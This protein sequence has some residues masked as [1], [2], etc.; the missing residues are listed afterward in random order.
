MDALRSISGSLNQ[1][2]AC[3]FLD[4]T[5]LQ[6]HL[7]ADSV[8]SAWWP[9]RHDTHAHLFSNTALFVS[10]SQ[11]QALSEAV[12]VL[13]E[14]MALPAWR[15][16]ALAQAPAIA[17]VDRGPYG[18][19]M[20]YDFHLTESGP[21]LIEINTNAGGAM[22]NLALT[23]AQH[24]CCDAGAAWLRTATDVARLE[25]QWLDM[26]AQEWALQRGAEPF[27]AAQ[28]PARTLAIVDEDPRQQYLYPE[29]LLFQH[30]FRQA[31]VDAV[32][33]APQELV[34]AQGQLQHQGR[35]V[36]MVYCRLTDFYLD[37]PQHAHLREAFTSGVCVFTPGPTA[38]A[39]HANKRHLAALSDPQVLA[40]M[41]VTQHMRQALA[42]V[43]PQTEQV[44]PQSAERLWA[45]RKQYFF[46]PLAGYG[47]KATYRGDKLTTK[48][49]AHIV[50]GDYVAQALIPPSQRVVRVGEQRKHL[51]ADVRAYAYDGWVQLFAARLYEGQTTNFRSDGGGFAPVFVTPT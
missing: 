12:Q 10:Q 43:V 25:S 9:G 42:Q 27:V 15:A 40:Q 14:A 1:G 35:R 48:T 4:E 20:G 28:G 47:S 49:W 24:V 44:T 16:Q 3:Y 33:A 36:D 29:F 17:Q 18:V 34:W 19:F 2:C 30:M 8:L 38:H 32:I 22:L 5:A 39:L 45:Q 6:Q 51:K 11:L 37:E 41:G 26:F 46:K 13:H 21:K 31:G 50:Q 7:L 23:R